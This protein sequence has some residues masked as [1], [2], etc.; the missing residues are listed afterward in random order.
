MPTVTGPRRDRW[1][2]W[3]ALPQT[4]DPVVVLIRYIDVPVPVNQKSKLKGLLER[5]KTS[6]PLAQPGLI[7]YVPTSVSWRVIEKPRSD[8]LV[9]V[10]V[11][12]LGPM[13]ATNWPAAS[14]ACG[15]GEKPS[16]EKIHLP[17]RAVRGLAG[18]V[19]G[20]PRV[21]MPRRS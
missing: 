7:W 4:T 1:D 12:P 13:L 18:H 3:F 21:A 15:N 11:G 2:Y 20:P 9:M 19:K 8:V 10:S 14:K 17:L 5:L 6:V 16:E